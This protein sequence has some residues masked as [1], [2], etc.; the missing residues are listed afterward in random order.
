MAQVLLTVP[1]EL[2]AAGALLLKAVSDLKAKVSTSQLVSDLLAPLLTSLASFK[3]I[4]A[5]MSDPHSQAYIAI[6]VAEV[7]ETLAGV[8]TAGV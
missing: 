3:A 4:G 7:I 6:I 2:V 1:D 5:D 8:P